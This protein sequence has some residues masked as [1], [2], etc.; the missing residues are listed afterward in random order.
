MEQFTLVVLDTQALVELALLV[1]IDKLEFQV[2]LNTA[3]Y[4]HMMVLQNR[5]DKVTKHIA[6]HMVVIQYLVDTQVFVDWIAQLD[7]DMQDQTIESY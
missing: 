4:Y 7:I 3:G 1:A 6:L 2:D 5:E